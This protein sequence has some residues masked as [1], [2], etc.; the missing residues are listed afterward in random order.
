MRFYLFLIV[1]ITLQLSAVTSSAEETSAETAGTPVET[2]LPAA[3]DTIP[4]TTAEKPAI[5]QE[6][7]Q[8]L[9]AGMNWFNS[10]EYQKAYDTFVA[11]VEKDPQNLSFRLNAGLAA[12]KLGKKGISL[13][14]VRSAYALDPN[15]RDT[16]RILQQVAD[17]A[18]VVQIPR[19]I[20]FTENLV[21]FA[22]HFPLWIC[23]VL[24][25][26]SLATLIYRLWNWLPLW[27]QARLTGE[28][29]HISS[30][31]YF[32]FLIFSVFMS[33]SLLQYYDR[34]L[35]RGTIII[36]KAE[37]R[38]LPEETAAPLIEFYEGFEVLV[39][40]SKET[41]DPKTQATVEWLKIQY[42]GSFQGWVKASDVMIT[43]LTSIEKN[44]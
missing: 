29:I 44:R 42:P 4:T 2:A 27:K 14:Y 21:N 6:P 22:K 30:L 24:T 33:L 26:L 16:A 17:D 31:N 34:S 11:G 7:L 37:V 10:K 32:I 13:A 18:R 28:S 23:V 19:Q 41:Q 1:T 35:I 12:M 39:R 3:T 15:S 25:I 20:L 38:T 36:S 8:L 9:Q 40:E 43:T 5:P